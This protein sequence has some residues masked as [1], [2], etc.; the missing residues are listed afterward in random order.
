MDRWDAIAIVGAVLVG[1][2]VRALAGGAWMLILWGVM[3][4]ALP[5]IREL[6]TKR[7][8]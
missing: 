1:V 4:L 6:R 3:L 7:A 5:V 8:E 2:G